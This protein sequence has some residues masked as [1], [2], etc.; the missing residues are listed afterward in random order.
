MRR[1]D[2][3]EKLGKLHA[4]LVL[5][6]ALGLPACSTLAP[7]T[8]GLP[9]LLGKAS[10]LPAEVADVV[11]RVAPKVSDDTAWLDYPA[12][13]WIKGPVCIRENYL[14]QVPERLLENEIKLIREKESLVS[15]LASKF[16]QPLKQMELIV[17]TA[18]EEAF[19]H[20]LPPVLVLAII[21]KESSFRPEARN[22][23]GATGLMQVMPKYHADKIRH[24]RHPAGLFNPQA[25]IRIGVRILAEYVEWAE[26]DV[27]RALRRYSGNARNYPQTVQKI[28][29][30]LQQVKDESREGVAGS[31]PFDL[32]ASRGS[33][34][35]RY[36]P[37]NFVPG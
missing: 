5:V 17:D 15:Y 34:A 29:E 35:L 12:E 6:S 16:A 20:Q 19:K 27:S 3:R 36:S 7:Y 31:T 10:T 26:G 2:F 33:F 30:E 8:P 18:F 23:S 13:M 14:Q 1:L 21:Q 11:T 37:V 9:A 4:A 25:N 28:A 22:P 24:I 32:P